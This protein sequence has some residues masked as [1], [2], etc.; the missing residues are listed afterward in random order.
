VDNVEDFPTISVITP[1][2]TENHKLPEIR[3]ALS[4]SSLSTELI[5]VINNPELI[6][7]IESQATNEKVVVAPRKGRG[8]AFLK[9]IANITGVITLL[10]HSDTIPPIGWDHAILSALKD[11]EV[12]GGGFSM[13]YG[14]SKPNLDLG[15][16]LM[17]QWFRISGELYGDRAMFI[18]SNILI[19]C[20]SVL[21]VP[22]FEDLRLVKCMHKHGR[23]VLLKERVETGAKTLREYG[24]LRYL[25]SFLLCRFWY[26]LGGSPFQIYNAYYSTKKKK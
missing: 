16:W 1:V 19:Y 26:A 12:V 17:N 8:F 24:L 9:G 25:G 13:T 15:I 21:E 11:P 3:K 4:S 22:L 2:H 5:I 23:V 10:L 18:R 20:L 7:Q 6:G 14:T